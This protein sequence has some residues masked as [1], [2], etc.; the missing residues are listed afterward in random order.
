[1]N[2]RNKCIYGDLSAVRAAVARGLD[3][4]HKQHMEPMNARLYEL[5]QAAD[6]KVFDALGTAIVDPVPHFSSAPSSY[7]VAAEEMVGREERGSPEKTL[8]DSF[9][10]GVPFSGQSGLGLTVP[11]F[12]R[13][14]QH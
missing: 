9:S 7:I 13:K 6:E 3:D 8:S 12:P 2:C 4:L 14:V 11:S 10:A 5:I 1:M